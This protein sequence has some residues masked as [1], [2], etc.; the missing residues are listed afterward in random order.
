VSKR[1]GRRPDTRP[2]RKEKV[3]DI[4]VGRPFEGLADETEWVALRELVPAATAPLRFADPA[5]ADRS[6]ILATVL[7]MAAPGLVKEDGRILL[8]LQS[9]AR[10]GDL[11]RDL[12]SVLEVALETD[13]GTFVE[14]HGLPGPGARLQDLLADGGAIAATLHDSFGFWLDGAEP[15]DPEVAASLERANAS[16][17]PTARLSAA[18]SAFWCRVPERS[19]LR[20]VLPEDEDAALDALARL[21][22]AG[23]LGLGEGTKYA[24]AFRAHGLLA[25]VWDLP[26]DLEPGTWEDALADLAKRY[27]EALADETP[28]STEQR[29][30]RDGLRGRQLT[31]R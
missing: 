19:H 16:I 13:P 30:A 21:Q 7:P 20:W 26:R 15:D 4:F 10:S 23:E 8:G 31:L 14:V 12:A 2:A 29:R 1:R 24:G 27:A 28:L 17:L 11:S 3:R 6:V 5:H 22:A 9:V 18:P 25:P